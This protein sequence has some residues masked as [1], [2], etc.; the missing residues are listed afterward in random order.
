MPTLL[1]TRFSVLHEKALDADLVGG[2]VMCVALETRL[3]SMPTLLETRFSVL[4]ETTLDAHLV[5]EEVK[6]LALDYAPCPPYFLE[7][8]SCFSRVFYEVCGLALSTLP[9]AVKYRL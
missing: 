4:H 6:C 7:T 9:A 5:G 3:C 2:E 8:R 1:E